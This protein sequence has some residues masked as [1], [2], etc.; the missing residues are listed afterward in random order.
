MNLSEL[1]F[2]IFTNEKDKKEKDEQYS[3]LIVKKVINIDI[4]CK[5]K[6]KM[7]N[8]LKN[9]FQQKNRQTY[10]SLILSYKL[11]SPITISH[12]L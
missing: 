3:N 2:F 4:C 12:I 1:P 5:L 11:H 8:F 10:K 7:S 9:N 6:C